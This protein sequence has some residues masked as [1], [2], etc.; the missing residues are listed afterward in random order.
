MTV[1]TAKT[2]VSLA[3]NP[4][5]Y[6]LASAV[7]VSVLA[8]CWLRLSITSDQLFVIRL[9]QLFGYFS[10][11]LWV[12]ALIITPL[13]K[14]VGD[15]RYMPYLLFARRAIGVSAAYFALLHV[16]IALWGQ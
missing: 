6:I 9:Q 4:R 5:F 1:R 13:H 16:C 10:V 7:C 8:A 11:F 14:V 12:G 15:R 2:P 3:A